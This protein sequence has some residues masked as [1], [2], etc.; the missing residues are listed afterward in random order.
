M[1]T[2]LDDGDVRVGTRRVANA[3]TDG[4]GTVGGIGGL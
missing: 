4:D 3:R 1:G 2:G